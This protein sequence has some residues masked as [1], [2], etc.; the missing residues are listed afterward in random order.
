LIGWGQPMA[1]R[2]EY[3]RFP[4]KRVVSG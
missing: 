1:I 4:G 2:D 3:G